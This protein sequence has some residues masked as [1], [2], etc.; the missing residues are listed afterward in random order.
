MDKAKENAFK[1]FLKLISKVVF[2]ELDWQ[3]KTSSS[4][5]K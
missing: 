5:P 1:T 2:L 4:L 3:E